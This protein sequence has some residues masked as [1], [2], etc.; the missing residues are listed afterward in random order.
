MPED[1]AETSTG[2]LPIAPLKHS[3]PTAVGVFEL[4]SRAGI[5]RP[6]GEGPA[7]ARDQLVLARLH[8][9]PLALL[10]L[11]EPPGN[12][13]RALVIEELW[14]RAREQIE[15]H[16]RAC[17][18]LP[19]PTGSGEFKAALEAAEADCPRLTPP[20]PPGRAAV[21]VCTVGRLEALQ[22]ALES[23]TRVSCSDFEIVVVDNRPSQLGTRE[24]IECFSALAPIRYVVEPRPGL[25]MARNAGV[26]AAVGAEYVAF[27]D[28]DVVADPAWLGWLLA[29]FVDSEVEAVTG[30]VLPLSLDSTAEKRFELYAGFGKGVDREIYDMAEHRASERFLYPYWGGMFGSG[31]SMAFRRDALLTLG[32]FDPAL[33]AGTPT[34]GGE[35]LAAFTDVILGGARIVYEPRSL[36]WHEH[37]NDEDALRTQVC[38][39]GVGL[40]AVLWRYL[41]TDWRF[42]AKLVSS[43]PAITRL[44]RRRSSDRDTDRLPSDL[45]RLELRGRLLGPWRYI[46][47]RRAARRNANRD[48]A[49]QIPDERRPNSNGS[50]V[51]HAGAQTRT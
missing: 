19:M 10:H 51:G 41:M 7:G 23:L 33:G 47:S 3:D 15:D 32:G 18:C 50:G 28:D 8:G 31:N 46:I 4:E 40:T 29:P 9:Q 20:R 12:E 13:D 5:V 11:L 30:L 21:I 24:L 2:F 48:A 45:T 17:G 39:Y 6:L 1:G 49:R 43:L 26:A 37:R 34:A 14:R 25:A 42:S 27:T 35:D 36:C 22:R 44:A 38:N 16:I